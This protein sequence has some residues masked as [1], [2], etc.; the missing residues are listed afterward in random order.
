MIAAVLQHR[1]LP[2]RLRGEQLDGVE[3]RVLREPPSGLETDPPG[4]DRPHSRRHFL[5]RPRGVQGVEGRPR[6]RHARV[7]RVVRVQ[8]AVQQRAQIS[9]P[10]PRHFLDDGSGQ[11]RGHLQAD[12]AVQYARLPRRQIPPAHGCGHTA[13]VTMSIRAF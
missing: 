3:E 7:R 1:V 8:Q 5:P 12:G 13:H 4:G 10:A 9:V 11:V 6:R 2:D